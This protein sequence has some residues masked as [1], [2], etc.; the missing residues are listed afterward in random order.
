MAGVIDI[1]RFFRNVA[2]R[3]DVRV[4]LGPDGRPRAEQAFGSRGNMWRTYG[5]DL[6][7]FN[8]KGFLEAMGLPSATPGGTNL[9]MARNLDELNSM[10]KKN[11]GSDLMGV[12]RADQTQR[13]QMFN[14]AGGLQAGSQPLFDPKTGL[15][16]RPP[17]S[18]EEAIKFQFEANKVTRQQNQRLLNNAVGTLRYGLGQ[19][20]K[21]GPFSLAT[22]QS[23]LLGQLSTTYNQSR[24][25]APDY[26][27]F[28]RPDAQFGGGG[29][30]GGQA[31]PT[32]N[33]PS[34]VYGQDQYA[35]PFQSEFTNSIGLT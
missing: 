25:D 10:L 27:Y 33:Q 9:G 20:N 7:D 19:V 32:V 2:L 6:G 15:P 29:Q 28:L 23:P 31:L 13:E 34:S 22:M 8:T 18:P 4:I 1:K 24:Y 12:M 5:E 11:Y 14:N 3:P 17:N 35:G 16:N 21:A 26:S 30:G